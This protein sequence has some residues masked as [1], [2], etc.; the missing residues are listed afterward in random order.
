MYKLFYLCDTFVMLFY[1][2]GTHEYKLFYLC[3]THV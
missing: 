2:C 1:L 3:G